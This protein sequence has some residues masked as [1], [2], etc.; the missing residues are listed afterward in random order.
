VGRLWQEVGETLTLGVSWHQREGSYVRLEGSTIVSES[1]WLKSRRGL[2]GDDGPR[3]V[4]RSSAAVSCRHERPREGPFNVA[5]AT[6]VWHE[7]GLAAC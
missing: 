2:R 3:S 4:A 7:R 1:E 6:R 5:W